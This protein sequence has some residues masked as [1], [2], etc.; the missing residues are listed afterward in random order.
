M[1]DIHFTKKQQ[2][3]DFLKARNVEGGEIKWTCPRCGAVN[4]GAYY[5]HEAKC[6]GCDKFR[7]P[8]LNLKDEKEA[9]EI[10]KEIDRYKTKIS[11]QYEVVDELECELSEE[12][13]KLDDLKEELRD[14]KTCDMNKIKAEW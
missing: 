12:R 11:N 2:V 13:R 4:F 5:S 10:A 1:T 8:R 6:G 7:F 3:I 9:T 14:L